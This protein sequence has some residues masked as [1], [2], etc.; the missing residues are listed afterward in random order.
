MPPVVIAAGIAGGAAIYG[1][2]KQAQASNKATAAQAGATDKA[3]EYQKQ[4]ELETKA[5]YEKDVQ[6]YDASRQILAQRYG[7]SLPPLGGQATPPP[8]AVPRGGPPPGMG[9][10]GPM[11]QP[12]GQMMAGAAQLAPPMAQGGTIGSMVA[13]P[14][15]SGTI[16]S[17]GGWNDWKQ[18]GL[19]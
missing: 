16:G 2:H 4:Q 19:A 18:Q 6:R 1:A 5:R 17:L 3:L 12:G 15:P 8:G 10:R 13:R 14:R 11:P 9:P 7:I